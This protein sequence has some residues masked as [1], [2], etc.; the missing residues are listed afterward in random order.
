MLGRIFLTFP[1]L[2]FFNSVNGAEDKG[3]M[4]QLNP[5]SFSSQIFWLI[6][7]FV[8][9]FIV[10]HFMFIPKLKR[11]RISRETK[12]DNY[13]SE[14]KKINQEIEKIIADIEFNLKKTRNVLDDE[15]KL[16]LDE[17]KKNYEEKVRVIERDYEKKKKELNERLLDSRNDLVKKVPEICVSLSDQ[18]FE[19]IMNEKSKGNIKDFN[20]VTKEI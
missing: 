17:N 9:L 6:I 16:V 1:I 19:K 5:D 8:T 2:F 14:T 15:I 13:L 4:P 20:E 7:F 18:L 10:I 3:G 11:V 12:I